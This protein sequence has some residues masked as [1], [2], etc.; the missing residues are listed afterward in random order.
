MQIVEAKDLRVTRAKV[1]LIVAHI[2]ISGGIERPLSRIVLPLEHLPAHLH[3]RRRAV[4]IPSQ[5]S[6]NLSQREHSPRLGGF[7]ATRKRNQKAEA[8]RKR[9]KR[10]PRVCFLFSLS[11]PLCFSFSTIPDFF[12]GT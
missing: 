1:T 7:G 8:P 3:L 11:L 6:L 4:R 12:D 2:L 9:R 10:R 5:L